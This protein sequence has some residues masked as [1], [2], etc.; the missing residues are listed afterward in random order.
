MQEGLQIARRSARGRQ[1]HQKSHGLRSGDRDQSHE[2]GNRDCKSEVACPTPPS[3]F[4]GPDVA[5]AG[6]IGVVSWIAE[7]GE[8]GGGGHRGVPCPKADGRRSAAKPVDEQP[9]LH[10]PE[11]PVWMTSVPSLGLAAMVWATCAR[12]YTRNGSNG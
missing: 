10:S 5:D 12:A 7:T 8:V 3:Y 1:C 6:S 11:I 2:Y 4:R 9:T